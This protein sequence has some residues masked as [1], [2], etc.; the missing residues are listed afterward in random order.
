MI[1]DQELRPS[2][3]QI[4]LMQSVLDWAIKLKIPIGSSIKKVDSLI[5]YQSTT[6]AGMGGRES[7]DCYRNMDGLGEVSLMT[8]TSFNNLNSP[9]KVDISRRSKLQSVSNS[10][11]NKSS[12]HKQEALYF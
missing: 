11:F 2:A 12:G 1:K 10:N 4:L 8:D 3:T 5:Y 6:A 7:T 9:T